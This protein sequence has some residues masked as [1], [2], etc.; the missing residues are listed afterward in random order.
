MRFRVSTRTTPLRPTAARLLGAVFALTLLAGCSDGSSEPE[1]SAAGTSASD[2]GGEKGGTSDDGGAADGDTTAGGASDGGG[3]T[4]AAVPQDPYAVTPAP[5]GFTAPD[6]CTGEGAYYVK[7]DGTATPELPERA[8]ETLTITADGIS[9]DDA[10]LTAT[11]GDGSS[12]PIEDMT[13]G[14]TASIDLW[15]ISVTS[16]CADTNLIEFDLID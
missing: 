12:R 9:G 3:R 13:L 4:A 16:V 6:P 2:A 14:E 7:V 15:T 11:L 1:E 5:D 10:Q 8:G